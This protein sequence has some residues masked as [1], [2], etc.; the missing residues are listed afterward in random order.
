MERIVLRVTE[1]L[2]IARCCRQGIGFVSLL[3]SWIL[4]MITT[5]NYVG[6]ETE[7]L[8]CFKSHELLISGSY[9]LHNLCR[10]RPH[11]PGDWILQSWGARWRK[12][13]FQ[14]FYGKT[15]HRWGTSQE[16]FFQIGTKCRCHL[17]QL[18]KALSSVYWIRRLTATRNNQCIWL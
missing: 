18:L 17:S 16:Y 1:S 11:S 8:C 5:E 7:V 3:S 12:I 13:F 15:W 2:W 9:N 4:Q 6:T 14:F 10:M